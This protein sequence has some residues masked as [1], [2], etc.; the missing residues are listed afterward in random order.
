M[1][2]CVPF[3]DVLCA[4]AQLYRLCWS[5]RN[6]EE[7]RIDLDAEDREENEADARTEEGNISLTYWFSRL[8]E[9]F[10]LHF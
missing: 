6:S 7:E 10:Y 9:D 8:T 1:Q 5:L 4:S 3:A 2:T